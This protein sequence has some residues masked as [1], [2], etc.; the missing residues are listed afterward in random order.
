MTEPRT[1]TKD[2]LGLIETD[3]R[4]DRGKPF[5]LGSSL[6]PKGINFAVF[7]KHA[8]AVHLVVFAPGE[9][10]PIAEFPFDPRFNRTGDIWH[11]LIAGLDHRVEYG[12]RVKR[13]PNDQ[14]EIHR[15]DDSTILLD[16]FAR[17]ISG[18]EL[19]GDVVVGKHRPSRP[20]LRRSLIVNGEFDWEEDQPLNIPMSDTIIYEMHVRGFTR[21]E[22][23][24]VRYPGTYR[25]LI[26]K[27]PYL[28]ELGITAVELLPISE[29]EEGDSDK[30]NPLTGERLLNYWGYSSIGFFA[31][32]SSY[33]SKDNA[34]VV[35]FKELVKALHRAGIE[36]ILDVV[37]NHTAEGN[38]KGPTHSFRGLDNSIYYL[39]DPYT[40][41]YANYSGCGNTMNC[42]HPVVRDLI[43]DCLRYWVT[44]MHVDGFRFDLASILGR[45]RDGSV[46]A[47]PPLLE[48]IACDP[49]LGNTKLIAEAWDAAGLY[50]VGSFPSYGRWAEWN[51]S[52]RDD[53]RRFIK[54]ESG[55][56]AGL[57]QRF[58]GSPDLYTHSGRA[59]N[60]SINFVTC[61]DGFTLK[62]MVSYN[63]KH[64]LANGEDNR[65][66]VN[67]NHSWNCG[68]EGSTRITLLESNV[69]ARFD[70]I[71]A[72]R[73]RQMKN[74]A[75][76]L[77]CSR[78]VP[79]L[80]AGDEFGRTQQGNN[81]AY[82]QDN[83]ISWL[84]WDLLEKNSELF[85]FF[86]ML[87]DFRK[88]QPALRH[89]CFH[90]NDVYPVRL[91]GVRPDSP[92][93]SFDS[94]SLAVQFDQKH[95][96]SS[97][98]LAA[99]SYWEP[100]DFHLPRLDGLRHWYRKLDT[101]LVS[102]LDIEEDN[103]LRRLPN[104]LSYQLAPRSIAVLIGR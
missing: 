53:I 74:A 60:H 15:F 25:G 55:Q 45:G 85:R 40:G 46:L 21:H 84:D 67:H 52:F 39:I 75:T 98:Y 86:R 34:A 100:L 72:L 82:C 24:G 16:P 42:N 31:P 83:E 87:I 71:D 44:E 61:H 80:L 49:I 76:L 3:F 11:C 35:E 97:I 91:H 27:I 63:E 48:A 93:M 43:L 104:Q 96:G 9:T 6:N 17:A 28:Q 23:S 69:E 77:L 10:D 22:S 64:N 29:F 14:P 4:I 94:R 38:D 30:I 102:P 26:E 103:N 95:E 50:Q 41:E 65:D 19:W 81:N 62:D 7:S 13:S 58:N 70:K 101:S 54:S 37:F 33:A 92:D 32:K 51:A 88:R 57:A 90:D 12:F 89:D 5:P 73:I 68:W 79:M 66:G 59:P 8:T 18:R 56:V 47:N 1:E 20:R 36:V 99:S 78:G 2:F